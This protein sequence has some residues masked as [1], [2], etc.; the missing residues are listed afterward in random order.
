MTRKAVTLSFDDGVKQDAQTIALL[1]K[2]GLKATFNLNSGKFGECVNLGPE[3]NNAVHD[4][5]QADEIRDVYQGME[6]A[7]H[8]CTHPD[9]KALS[10]VRII[11][12]LVHDYMRLSELVGYEV[13]G[14]AY[15]GGPPNYNRFVMETIRE[16]TRIRY[17]RAFCSTYRFD[18]PEDYMEWRP[19]VHV[20]DPAFD[21]LLEE[22]QQA[23]GDALFYLWAHSYEFD[24]H[25][26]WDRVEEIFEKLS[27]L[28]GA[29]FLTNREVL[30]NF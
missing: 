18:I 1:K 2:Y 9:L 13:I 10:K 22:F 26:A 3:Q 17:A 30:L 8:T 28:E 23:E 20:L 14:M 24:V 12:E 4:K 19:T 21:C 25:N 16:N 15:P 27:R 6:V 5:W 7:A 29:A 11:E